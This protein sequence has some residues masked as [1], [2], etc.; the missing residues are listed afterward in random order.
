MRQFLQMIHQ[1]PIESQQKLLEAEIDNWIKKG[2]T[3]QIDDML[4]IG[5][6]NQ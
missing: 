3:A 6:K 5:V 1:Q 2:K 4:V